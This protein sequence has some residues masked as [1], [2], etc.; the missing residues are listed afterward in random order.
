MKNTK[1]ELLILQF[2]ICIL[3]YFFLCALCGKNVLLKGGFYDEIGPY[4]QGGGEDR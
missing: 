4:R 2:N 1:S 3:Y